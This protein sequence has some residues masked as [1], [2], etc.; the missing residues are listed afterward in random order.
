[1]FG[2]RPVD[3][4]RVLASISASKQEG[5]SLHILSSASRFSLKLA[6][7]QVDF[8][9]SFIGE[10][11]LSLV[12]GTTLSNTVSD[13]FPDTL[14]LT[15]PMIRSLPA[16]TREGLAVAD[17]FYQ[18]SIPFLSY[19]YIGV[20]ICCTWSVVRTLKYLQSSLFTQ[21]SLPCPVSHTYCAG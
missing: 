7:V 13:T 19:I 20:E 15:C 21:G 16:P 11:L 18:I 17:Y 2:L 6:L 3:Q 8:F 1:M 14:L 12:G 9:L 5:L 4:L 10:A